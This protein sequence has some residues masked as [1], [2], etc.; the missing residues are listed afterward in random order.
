MITDSAIPAQSS[1]G[2]TSSYVGKVLQEQPGL[3]FHI[4]IDGP[5]WRDDVDLPMM[6]IRTEA[7]RTNYKSPEWRKYTDEHQKR[8]EDDALTAADEISGISRSHL[9]NT[10]YSIANPGRRVKRTF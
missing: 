8:L 3:G 7:F 5:K 4:S 6:E 2:D 10:S 1:R 9:W